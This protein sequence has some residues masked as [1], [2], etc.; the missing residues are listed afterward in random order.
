M[1]AWLDKRGIKSMAEIRGRLA[2]RNAERP[3]LY[4]RLQ[5][6]KALTGQA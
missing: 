2:R 1:G 6:V 5:Y 4:G 3:E